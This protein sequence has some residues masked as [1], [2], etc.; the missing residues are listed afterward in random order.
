M[1]SERFSGEKTSV[2]S[3]GGEQLAGQGALDQ[4]NGLG[5]PEDGGEG[6][7]AWPLALA[8]QHLVKRLE[9]GP[10]RLEA[11]VL[12]RG[13]DLVLDQLGVLAAGRQ[14]PEAGHEVFHRR[15]LARIGGPEALM[16][17]D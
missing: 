2:I 13:I 17:P 9:P 8:Q 6:A 7:E 4:G 5:K 3:S 16:G 11:G 1:T 14:G 15:P 10:E 12:A